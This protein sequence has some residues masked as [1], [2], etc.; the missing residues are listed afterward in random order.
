MQLPFPLLLHQLHHFL[1]WL[2]HSLKSSRYCSHH[3]VS[4]SLFSW[5]HLQYYLGNIRFKISLLNLWSPL[6]GRECNLLL[7]RL[8]CMRKMASQK[9]FKAQWDHFDYVKQNKATLCRLNVWEKIILE[10]VTFNKFHYIASDFLRKKT[11]SIA[12]IRRHIKSTHK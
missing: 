4:Y 9:D 6:Q 12:M 8:F 11:V 7:C 10:L 5:C 1:K 2:S 3:S